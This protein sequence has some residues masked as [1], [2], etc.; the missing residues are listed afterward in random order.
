MSLTRGIGKQIQVGISK[1]TT[2][3]STPVTVTYWLATNDWVIDEKYNNAID[4]ETYGL[5]E[6]SV[7]ETRVKN[8]AEGSFNIPIGDQ[9]SVLFFLSLLGT[10]TVNTHA[11][12]SVVYDHVLTVAQTIQHQ[13]L[14]FYVHDPI[15]GV[16]YSHANGVV[17]KIDINYVLGKFVDLTLSIKALKGVAQS[18]YS[19][20]QSL[21]NRFVPQYLTFSVAPTYAGIKGTL[22]ATGTAA[23]TV[24]VTSLSISTTLLQIGMA[25]TGS[26]IPA[27]T[28]V[29]SIVSASAFDLSAATTGA[30]G[31]MTFTGSAIKLKTAKIS[32]DENAEDDDVLGSTSPRDFLNKEFK[33][34]G[35]LEA[36]WEN[37]S[38]FKTAALANSVQ[39]MRFKLTNSDV[40]IGTSANPALILDFPRC[41]FTEISRPVKIK[42]IMYQ[43]IK[44]KATYSLT[45]ALLVKGTA[46]NTVAS[47]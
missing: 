20:S 9:S 23:S 29:A 28:T 6:D 37:E 38:D 10:D 30:V 39:A 27:G 18:S 11:G 4:V 22:T 17:H 34:E 5:I 8:W 41:Y 35:S 42:D 36:I 25:V 13:S 7:S 32:F 14:S 40:T 24:H 47:Y 21:E 33:V 1:E 15:T 2:R 31:T 19:P 46:T 3:G 45:D 16:D 43:S 12:E 26:N 44:F